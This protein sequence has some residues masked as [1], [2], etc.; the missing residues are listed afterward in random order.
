[1]PMVYLADVYAGEALEGIPRGTVKKLRIVHLPLSLSEHG[2]PRTAWSAWNGPWDI[3]RI[4]GTVPVEADG[5]A[6]F[7]VPAN[8]PISV[9]PLDAEGKAVQLMRSWFTGMPGEILLLR[10]AATR[11]AEQHATSKRHWPIIARPAELTPWHGPTRGFTLRPRSPAGAGAKCVACHN[12]ATEDRAG[13]TLVSLRGDQPMPPWTSKLPGMR[14]RDWGG[15]FS[16]STPTLHRFVRR[17]GME[18]DYARPLPMEFHAEHHR[19]RADAPQG[20]P[21][22]SHSI[23]RSGTGWSPGSTSTPRSTAT[24][25]DIAGDQACRTANPP[26]RA[27]ANLRQRGRLSGAMPAASSRNA[28]VL[29]N[30]SPRGSQRRPL[31]RLAAGQPRQRAN[32]KPPPRYER[33][34]DLG[35]VSA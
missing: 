11:I 24:W 17:P 9:Q 13:T 7:R 14:N 4:L 33:S 12:G 27:A 32:I 5:S 29:P 26:R 20:P 10:R 19:A 21:R 8:T 1:M 28:A 30:R 2:R 18:S 15:K 34:I 31:P 16:T 3:K 22:T 23:P 35:A 6:Y 25:A